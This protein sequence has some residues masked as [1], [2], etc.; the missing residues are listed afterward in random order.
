MNDDEETRVGTALQLGGVLT[1]ALIAAERE[2]AN[3][4]AAAFEQASYS[5]NTQAA[6]KYAWEMF[7]HWC[8]RRGYT[9]CPAEPEVLRTYITT[10]AIEGVESPTGRPGRPL[11]ESTLRIHLAAIRLAHQWAK[12]PNPTE[13]WLT[14]RFFRGL[15]N[16]IPQVPKAKR[17]IT[18]DQLRDV[19]ESMGVSTRGIRDKAILLVG[20]D[21]G[22]R[23]RSEI[24]SMD[25]EH[26]HIDSGRWVWQIPHTKT[27]GHLEVVIP[28]LDEPDLCPTT[29]LSLWIR[30][31]EKQGI[32]DGPVFRAV[33]RWGTIAKATAARPD[34]RV[35]TEVVAT[36]VKEAAEALGLDPQ[37][38]G[39]HSLRSGFITTM[40]SKGVPLRDIMDRTG[41]KSF[42]VASRYIQSGNRFAENDAITGILNKSR[43]GGSGEPK[44]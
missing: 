21:S 38:Y 22:G 12:A 43:K 29:A 36:A 2:R 27:G 10:A 18:D 4:Q 1:P 26:L 24:T 14:E 35:N 17:R 19:T 28:R 44:E 39:G 33:N 6:Y 5:K 11:K 25:R 42:E 41:H 7:N 37:F 32:T 3:A 8:E 34:P 30:E 23:R 40:A 13:P 15:R 20:F 9:A 16:T 31:L